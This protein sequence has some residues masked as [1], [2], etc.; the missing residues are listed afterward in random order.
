MTVLKSARGGGGSIPEYGTDPA[1]PQPGE[2]WVLR[3]GGG[4]AGGGEIKAF[5]GLGF[6][7]LTVGAGGPL[8]YQL[9]YQTEAG[10]TV[11]TALS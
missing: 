1:S 10:T 7:L 4:G 3:S 8:T 11:R 9:S 6:P 2:T 5:M